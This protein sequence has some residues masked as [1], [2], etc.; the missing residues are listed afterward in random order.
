MKGFLKLGVVLSIGILT[1][2]CEPAPSAPSADAKAAEADGVAQAQ[3]VPG[4]P[5][6]NG[7]STTAGPSGPTTAWPPGSTSAGPSGS[8]TA[9]P[10]GSTSAGPSSGTQ[11]GPADQGRGSSGGGSSGGGGGGQPG[12][13]AGG[14][15]GSTATP[16]PRATPSTCSAT[17]VRFTFTDLPFLASSGNFTGP[18]IV[19]D[20]TP[21]VN[22]Y[23]VDMVVEISGFAGTPTAPVNLN[24]LGPLTMRLDRPGAGPIGFDLFQNRL[25]TGGNFLGSTTCDNTWASNGGN[26]NTAS[27]P[28]SGR[29]VPVG[30]TEPGFTEYLGEPLGGQ[31]GLYPL[32][33][34]PGPFTFTCFRME[35]TLATRPATPT[36]TATPIP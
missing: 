4:V 36:P 14:G 34:G 5:P 9:W 8:T 15:G 32:F 1:I 31:Y 26:F 22:C 29:F 25:L 21:F 13:N 20:P 28:Y 30:G 27:P 6:P 10:P 33:S 11:A 3:A 17:S 12:G 19:I 23:V 35:F 2:S 16:T 24:T 18:V 7:S